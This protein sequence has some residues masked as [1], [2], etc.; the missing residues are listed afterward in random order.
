MVKKFVSVLI[1]FI[2]M[3]TQISLNVN[4]LECESFVYDFINEKIII[5]NYTGVTEGTITIPKKI[6]GKEVL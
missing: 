5:T 2:I 6:E 1:T 3:V 4:A